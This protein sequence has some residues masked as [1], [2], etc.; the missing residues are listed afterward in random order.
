MQTPVDYC[1]KYE[2][3]SVLSPDGASELATGIKVDRYLLGAKQ[4]HIDERLRVARKIQ[5]DLA[6]RRK[7]DPTAK[8]VVRVHTATGVE[9]HSYDAL[10]FGKSDQLWALL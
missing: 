9:E 2:N 8:I 1:E 10:T 3:L 4:T 5:N 6:I 7:A